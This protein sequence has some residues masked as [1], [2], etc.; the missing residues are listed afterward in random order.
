MYE[1]DDLRFESRKSEAQQFLI[2]IAAMS[3]NAKLVQLLLKEGLYDI[4]MPQSHRMTPIHW[5]ATLEYCPELKSIVTLLIHAGYDINGRNKGGYTPLHLVCVNSINPQCDPLVLSKFLTGFN[6]LYR[7]LH[8]LCLPDYEDLELVKVL[9]EKGAE[10]NVTSKRGD[11]PL[12]LCC[13]LSKPGVVEYLLQCG[14]D[15]NFNSKVLLYKVFYLPTDQSPEILRCLLAHGIDVS[16]MDEECFLDYLD[17]IPQ[18]N[19]S[20]LF[21]VL[22]NLGYKFSDPSLVIQEPLSLQSLCTNQ[23]RQCL[24]PTL[25]SNLMNIDGLPECIKQ[26]IMMKLV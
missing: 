12:S 23:V 3:F 4:Q 10:V 11:T 19:A 17:T 15:V 8:T 2:D 26:Y 22:L 14:A 5:I 7:P 6:K 24:S 9:I 18:Q 21:H 20:S 1:E 13:E 16:V 25:Y